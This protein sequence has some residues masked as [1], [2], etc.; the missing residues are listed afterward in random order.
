MTRKKVKSTRNL[1]DRISLAAGIFIG[2]TFLVSGTGKIFASEKVPAQVLDFISNVM[3]EILV[4]PTTI[5]FLYSI[6]I[7]YIIPWMEL[8]LG[9]CLLIGFMPRLMAALSL[10]LFSVFLGTNLWL[11]TQS[12]H[13]TCASCF[14]MWEKIFGSFTPLQSLIYDAVLI[15]AAILVIVF[16]TGDFFN[17]RP[18]LTNRGNQTK[19][20]VS[21][22]KLK[23]ARLCEGLRN[24]RLKV[25]PFLKPIGSKIAQHPYIS[26]LAGMCFLGLIAYSIT[27]QFNGA[28]V[29]QNGTKEKIPVVFDISV[30][31]SGKSAVISWMTDRPTLSNIEICTEDGSYIGTVIGERPVI[32]HKLIIDGLSH[33]TTY[34]F[35]IL[36]DGKQV[37][38]G[39]N[40]FT[41]LT[42]EVSPLLISDVRVSETA[43]SS[44]VITWTTDRPATSEVEYWIPGSTD[45]HIVS[46]DDFVTDHRVKLVMLKVDTMYHYI[47]KS[48]ESNKDQAEWGTEEPVILISSI[49]I[50]RYAPDFTLKSLNGEAVTLSDYRGKIVMLDFWLWSCQKCR[51]KLTIIQEVFSTIPKEKAAIFA[52]HFKGRDSVI[53]SY[54]TNEGLTLPVL[55]DP[56]GIVNDL[57]QTINFPTT[58]FIDGNGIIRAIDPQF[59]TVEELIGIINNLS[60]NK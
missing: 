11:V 7:P 53:Q 50:G 30:E 25:S 20:L 40:Y 33:G 43:E 51:E 18:W 47:V 1:G 54:V 49:Q 39:E 38:S 35:K 23:M 60:N 4:S 5:D 41:T 37:L 17:S 58:F 26:L 55:L 8:I 29:F 32:S 19:H 27:I 22:T 42:K 13:A 12:K 36:S 24:I 21:A 48:A 28:T 6:F 59:T 44:V 34:Y 56:E 31:A 10:P 14:G 2:L 3:P 52:I 15:T 16:Q 46:A 9:C 57:Y 45:Q